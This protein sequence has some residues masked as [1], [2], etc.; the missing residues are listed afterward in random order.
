MFSTNS[1]WDPAAEAAAADALKVYIF[2]D[3][4]RTMPIPIGGQTPFVNCANG[5]AGSITYSLHFAGHLRPGDVICDH[6]SGATVTQ[7]N[8]LGNYTAI[9]T[10][11]DASGQWRNRGNTAP[12]F[13]T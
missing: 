13:A 12:F 8:K 6:N 3:T 2:G 10:A 7:Y 11:E 4:Y 9:L 5:D 1:G